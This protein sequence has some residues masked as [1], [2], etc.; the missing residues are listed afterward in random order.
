[1]SRWPGQKMRSVARERPRRERGERHRHLEGGARRVDAGDRLVDERRHRVVHPAIPLRLAHARIEQA[2]VEGRVGGHRQHLAVGRVEHDRAGALAGEM[3]GRLLLQRGVDGQAE[4][5]AGRALLAVQL[6]DHPT[7]RVD[8]EL[9]LAGAAAQRRLVVLLHARAADADAG[10]RQH[11]IGR[12]LALVGRR[13]VAHDM[14]Q[15]LAVGIFPRGAEIDHDAGQ[16]R[17]GDLDPRHLLPI[18]EVAEHDGDEALPL[19]Q[20]LRDP[21]ARGV[22]QGDHARE[23]VQQ[24]PPG[25]TPRRGSA[26]PASSSGCRRARCRSGRGCVRAAARSAAC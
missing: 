26:V 8:L 17:G 16:V 10:Q 9:H 18:E 5:D 7:E 15:Q 24:L 14:R 6:A 1:M 23:G 21:A 2:R 3:V 19:R 13:H 4:F 22:G 12:H 20:R 25:A 11:R